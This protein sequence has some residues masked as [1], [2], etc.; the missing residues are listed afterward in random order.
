MDALDVKLTRNVMEHG[1]IA[2][3]LACG[4]MAMELSKRDGKKKTGALMFRN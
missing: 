2:P 3:P 4:S 1:W